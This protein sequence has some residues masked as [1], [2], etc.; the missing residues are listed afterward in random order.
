MDGTL[1]IYK[2]LE[3][4]NEVELL[5]IATAYNELASIETDK[6]TQLKIGVIAC[7]DNEECLAALQIELYNQR[8]KLNKIGE[9]G[10]LLYEY[11]K[12]RGPD[13]ASLL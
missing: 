8:H 13:E 12:Q 7:K 4:M 6:M 9:L 2:Q 11:I 5:E 1:Q 3:N 10:E